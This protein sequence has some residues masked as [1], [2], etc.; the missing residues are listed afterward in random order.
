MENEI[1]DKLKKLCLP[2]IRNIFKQNTYATEQDIEDC[3]SFVIQN[4]LE[5]RTKCINR[6]AGEPSD[7][8]YTTIAK[9][10]SLDWSKNVTSHSRD[11]RAAPEK[12][13]PNYTDSTP[14]D[15]ILN[16]EIAIKKAQD[17]AGKS[18]EGLIE[19]EDSSQALLDL[20][21]SYRTKK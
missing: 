6:G 5:G 14:Q 18:I 2:V 19:F 16:L 11:R 8:F 13:A 15:T 9:N 1:Y 20:I 3:L 17:T 21:N 10:K 4:C 12:Q 7:G